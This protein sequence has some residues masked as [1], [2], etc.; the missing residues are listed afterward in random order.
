MKGKFRKRASTVWCP[1]PKTKTEF[2]WNKETMSYQ[3][4]K[5][6]CKV[7]GWVNLINCE[8]CPHLE[9]FHLDND[10]VFCLYNIE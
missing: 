5:R 9:E 8:N 10:G 6:Q 3:E 2:K 7:T 1:K 4:T